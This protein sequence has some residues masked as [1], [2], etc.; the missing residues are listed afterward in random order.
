MPHQ[1]LRGAGLG[2][3]ASWFG[4]LLSYLSLTNFGCCGFWLYAM[5]LLPGF[6]GVGA[7]TLLIDYQQ[8]FAALALPPL[9]YVSASRIRLLVR[10]S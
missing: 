5:S 10:G 7:A 4:E 2:S 8:Y 1:R 9:Y 3:G 6:V